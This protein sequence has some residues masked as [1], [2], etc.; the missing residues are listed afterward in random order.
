MPVLNVVVG[1]E[2]SEARTR[3]LG[4]GIV[5]HARVPAQHEVE[6][7]R[8]RLAEL[9]GEGEDPGGGLLELV[10]GGVGAPRA[11]G[12]DLDAPALEVVE[13]GDLL[14]RLPA[15]V[16]A[17]VAAAAEVVR[18]LVHA[19]ALA[20]ERAAVPLA[21]S[22]VLWN[23]NAAEPAHGAEA[24]RAGH[25][26]E[27]RP[28]LLRRVPVRVAVP[29]AG[30]APEVRAGVRASQAEALDADEHVGAAGVDKL[31]DDVPGEPLDVQMRVEALH[32]H[33]H[34]HGLVAQ[35]GRDLDD[36]GESGIGLHV[37]EVA[38]HG[39]DHE[40]VVA[41]PGAVHGGPQRADLDRVAQRGAR[42]VAFGH[43]ELRRGDPRD[44]HATS[45]VLALRRAVRRGHA[46]TSSVLVDGA[47]G[48]A[49]HA[50]LPRA[51][52]LQPDGAATLAFGEAVGGV[53]EGE[54]APLL[55]K[56]AHL[57][58][59]SPAKGVVL[60]HDSLDQVRRAVSPH[61]EV[62]IGSSSRNQ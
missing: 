59:R 33:A 8:L 56:H 39:G 51:L 35:H 15:G 11:H 52:K 22:A 40:W 50:A 16:L 1:A 41:G 13:G 17:R 29:L 6:L 53:V 20:H 38:L 10:V 37:G 45:N 14:L 49:C 55:G 30:S 27:V 31:R 44:V 48:E 19:R 25:V 32:M 57:A 36:P 54:T 7:L 47:S 43:R 58:E 12:K 46:G 4:G 9:Q 23:G 24:S 34:G 61:S 3:V 26:R 21:L 42:A 18:P 28:L 62:V 5:R 2:D 60:S